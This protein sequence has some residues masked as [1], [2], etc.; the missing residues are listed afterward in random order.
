MRSES[1]PQKNEPIP[2]KTQLSS[3]TVEIPVRDQPIDSEIGLRKTLSENIAPSP[4]H[5]TRMPA[6][7][8]IQP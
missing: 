1:A 3:A 5:V 4:M 8:M 6:P 7:T 2:M